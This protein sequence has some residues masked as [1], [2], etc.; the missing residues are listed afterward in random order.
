L[1]FGLAHL[2]HAVHHPIRIRTGASFLPP[3]AAMR[4]GRVKTMSS[5]LKQ[6]IAG[7]V[8]A[9]MLASVVVIRYWHKPSPEANLEANESL[10]R[11]GFYLRESAHDAGIDFTHQAPTLDSKL[12]HIMPIINS[13][14]ASVSIV[15]FD[16]DGLLDIY[17]VNSGE[18][19][20]N[21]LYKNLGNG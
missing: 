3:A 14:G 5:L 15:D 6:I 11:Y 1:P 21:R 18:G 20:K 17:V 7:L 2:P 13:M 10:S 19:T 16:R 8:L 12:E 9:G 4:V